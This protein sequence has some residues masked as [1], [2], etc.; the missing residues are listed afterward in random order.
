MA[1]I[2]GV[3]LLSKIEKFVRSKMPDNLDVAFTSLVSLLITLIVYILFIM[4]L[5]GFIS[6]ISC[7][8]LGAIC[9]SNS[10]IVRGVAGFLAS[11][12]FLPMVAMGMHH[13]LVALYA[14]ELSQLPITQR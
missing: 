4:P 9:M 3:W 14:I 11:S 13:G 10:P 1:V 8:A 2:A 7:N 6:R 12:L 5:T